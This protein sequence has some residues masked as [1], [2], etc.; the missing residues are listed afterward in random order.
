[1]GPFLRHGNVYTSTGGQY[2]YRIIGP[3][4]RLYDREEL[5]WPCCR[6]SWKSKEPSWRRIGTRFVPDIASKKCPSYS[7]EIFQPGAKAIKTVLT[8][9]S[10]K[11]DSDM[12][13]WWYSKHPRS[14]E[15]SNLIP[16]DL[17]KIEA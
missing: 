10:N 7:V 9:F 3:C 17:P 12:Q 2:S 1:M 15:P 8:L 4:C 6:I 11:F 16:P 14:R 13:E 5:P